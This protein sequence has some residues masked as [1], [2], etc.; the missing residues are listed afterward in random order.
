MPSIVDTVLDILQNR[1][2]LG[3]PYL[4]WAIS[5]TISIL[6]CCCI[7]CW[8]TCCRKKKSAKSNEKRLSQ[9]QD[10]PSKHHKHSIGSNSGSMEL[11]TI[12]MKTR[13]SIAQYNEYKKQQNAL[14]NDKHAPITNYKPERT[15]AGLKPAKNKQQQNNNNYPPQNNNINNTYNNNR[16]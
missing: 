4:Y 16:N 7:C 2:L 5:A 11:T 12:D 8:Y 9:I 14:K 1:K 15:Y 3:F 10:P 13:T 6:L